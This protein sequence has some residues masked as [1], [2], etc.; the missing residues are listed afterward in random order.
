MIDGLI[1]SIR[2]GFSPLGSPLSPISSSAINEQKTQ[3]GLPPGGIRFGFRPLG[4]AGAGVSLGPVQPQYQSGLPPDSIRFGVKP[5]SSPP[6]GPGDG[7]VQKFQSGIPPNLLRFGFQPRG[8][9]TPT[10]DQP[11]HIP[12]PEPT[13]TGGAGAPVKKRHEGQYYTEGKAREFYDLYPELKPPEPEATK[14]VAPEEKQ[15][16]QLRATSP[17]IETLGLD[18]PIEVRLPSLNAEIEKALAEDDEA[19]LIAILMAIRH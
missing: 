19:A 14:D 11:P 9:I 5:R 8:A 18:K 12:R 2:F 6:Q 10:L 17:L 13:D 15:G 3:G 7:L 4:Q 1:E 16:P